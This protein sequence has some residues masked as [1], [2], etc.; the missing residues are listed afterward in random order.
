MSCFKG[1]SNL[2]SQKTRSAYIEETHMYCLFLILTSSL[3][4]FLLSSQDLNIVWGSK[5]R[6]EDKGGDMAGSL[7]REWSENTGK[8]GNT[9]DV[10][11]QPWGR[12][13]HFLMLFLPFF[14]SL[15]AG[16]F[17]DAV[18]GAVSVAVAGYT[19]GHLGNVLMPDGFCRYTESAGTHRYANAPLA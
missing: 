9:V 4:L 14:L 6:Q 19:L 2:I 10:F 15:C 5:W 11:S 16:L 3:S 17:V 12:C 8:K 7:G 1:V 13:V 18:V